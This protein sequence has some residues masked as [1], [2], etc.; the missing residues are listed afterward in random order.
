MY[1]DCQYFRPFSGITSQYF[2]TIFSPCCVSF[3]NF[4]PPGHHIIVNTVRGPCRRQQISNA[5]LLSV[6]SGGSWVRESPHDWYFHWKD[7]RK[8][9]SHRISFTWPF[10]KNLLGTA[11]S[12]THGWPSCVPPHFWLV[13]YAL[14]TP[15]WPISHT[16]VLTTFQKQRTTRSAGVVVMTVIATIWSMATPCLRKMLW[17]L[18][19]WGHNSIKQD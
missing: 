12:Q 15:A 9:W 1:F 11:W 18:V 16:T 5:P 2:W 19:A 8:L 14:W 13:F 3:C 4:P 17:S 10:T 6:I 7:K